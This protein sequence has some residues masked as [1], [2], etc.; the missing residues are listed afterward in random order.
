M[1]LTPKPKEKKIVCSDP[2]LGPN[3][4]FLSLIFSPFSVTLLFLAV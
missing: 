2:F 4:P 1:W 3:A